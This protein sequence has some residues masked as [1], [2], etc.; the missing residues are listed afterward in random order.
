[1]RALLW[2]ALLSLVPLPGWGCAASVE[3]V[4][5]A[6]TTSTEDSGLFDVLIPAFE[7][8]HPKLRV[9]VVAVGSGEALAIG[10]RGDA[11]VLLVHSP[12]AESTFVAEGHGH[13]RR[14]VMTNDFVLVGDSA[15]AA[16]VR[17]LRDAAAA[18]RRI[19]AARARF[20]S[21]GDR[22]GTHTKE[23]ELWQAAGVAPIDSARPTSEESRWYVEVG[24]GMGETLRIANETGAYT[25]SDRGTYLALR[26]SLA[27]PVLVEGDARLQN[28]YSV[29]VVRRARNPTGGQ[30]FAE[31]IV[32]NEAQRLI[33]EFGT[34][35]FGQPLFRP[36]TPR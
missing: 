23:L 16:R 3:S 1:M 12:A 34:D 29:I 27:L 14:A 7:A 30:A 20:V 25:L 6:S 24:Q 28:P 10:R 8:A 9:M 26:N 22:S 13:S 33:G 15:D 19:A 18:F 36:T 21:R 11:D 17:G 32:G 2:I 4:V 35:R 5:L 31:W